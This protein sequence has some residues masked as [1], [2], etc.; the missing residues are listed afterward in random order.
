MMC[1]LEAI[2]VKEKAIMEHELF[3]SKA[4]T[5]LIERSIEVCEK[6]IAPFLERMSKDACAEFGKNK[7]IFLYTHWSERSGLSEQ[8]LLVLAD[9]SNDYADNRYALKP[10]NKKMCGTWNGKQTYT[11]GYEDCVSLEVIK[12][13]L[14]KYCWET[15]VTPSYEFVYGQ[16]K[17]LTY[18]LSFIPSPSCI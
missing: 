12:N 2:A 7:I 14:A 10:K 18:A 6:V 5:R 8:T 13:Y 16:G 11:W 1:G 17:C 3:E 15:K 4:E 9:S